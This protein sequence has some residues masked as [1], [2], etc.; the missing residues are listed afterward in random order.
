MLIDLSNDEIE[1]LIVILNGDIN[2]SKAIADHWKISEE[3]HSI[4]TEIRNL[5][6][7]IRKLE[8]AKETQTLL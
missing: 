4:K 7:L 5:K 1:T 2:V 3:F 8:N 6:E